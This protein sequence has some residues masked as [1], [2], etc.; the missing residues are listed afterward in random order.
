VLQ[1]S[2][3]L[4]NISNCNTSTKNLKKPLHFYIQQKMRYNMAQIDQVKE[5]I[6]FLKAMI[7]TLIVLDSSMIAYIYN[8]KIS[9]NITVMIVIV[10]VSVA[11]IVLLKKILSEIKHLKEL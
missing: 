10:F 7:I 1:K 11:I 2:N 4:K 6:G 5:L 8:H 9:D 3:F